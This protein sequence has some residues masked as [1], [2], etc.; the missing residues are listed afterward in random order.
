[1]SDLTTL[2]DVKLWLNIS[3]STDDAL[4]TRLITAASRFIETWS[5]RSFS[6]VASFTETRNGSGLYR[7]MLA[8]YPVTAVASVTVNTVLIPLAS[9]SV[10][11]GYFWDSVGN[12]YLSGY[13]F[14]RALQ[15]VSITYSAGF[16][17]VPMEIAQACIDLVSIRYKERGRIGEASKSLGGNETVSFIVKD[18]PDNM[19]TILQNYKK[20]VPLA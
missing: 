2:A 7:L 11:S 16:T 13:L 15:N 18:M 8:N 19:K 5:N 1:M 17:S 10:A 12:I 4:L 14:T 9:S 3:T 6:G 20:V